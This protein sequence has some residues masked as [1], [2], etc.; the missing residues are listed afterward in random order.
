[1]AISPTITLDTTLTELY[2]RASTKN[3]DRRIGQILTG[4][5]SGLSITPNFPR[6]TKYVYQDS[7]FN[8]VPKSELNDDNTELQRSLAMKYLSLVPQRDAF[9]SGDT[10]IVMFHVDDSEEQIAHDK[11]EAEKSIESLDPQQKPRFVFCPGP[12]K[13]PFEE[14]G[15]DALAYKLVLDGLD[16]YPLIVPLDKHWI[17]N[18]KGVLA[19]SGLPTPKAE[20]IETSG[21][22]QEADLCCADCQSGNTIF[23]PPS[24]N[25]VRGKWLN[26]QSDRIISA[27]RQRPIPFVLKNQQ[28]FG[29]AGTY[30]VKNEEDREKVIK[31]FS[32]DLNHKMLSQITAENHHLKP[33]AV[34]LSDLVS[35]PIGDYG[36]TFFVTDRGD[37][38]FLA[39]S[40]QMIDE[41]SAWVGST[42]NYSRQDALEKRFAPIMNQIAQWLHSYDYYGPAGADILET[43]GK[44]RNGELNSSNP[45]LHIVDLNV[46]TSGSMCLPLMKGH[47]QRRGL[48][49]ASSFSIV[50]KESRESFIK[51]W[52]KEFESGRMCILSWYEDPKGVESIG[53][54]VVGAEDEKTLQQEIERVRKTTDEVTF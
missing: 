32:S 1:M 41:N 27:I 30:M 20:V 49:S 3:A 29:G 17:I 28:T 39:V 9:I 44:P 4:A 26:E 48:R 22:S 19:N 36:L 7:P 47:F 46:R 53:D 10:A 16:Q 25:G 43:A 54:V 50:V 24:C 21:H 35:D 15:V 37:A 45:E 11:S 33:G 2:K 14:V 8:S 13:I 42:I 23:I 51:R 40:E 18:S 12:R 31:D 6:N 5:N 34:I 38:I 52:Q